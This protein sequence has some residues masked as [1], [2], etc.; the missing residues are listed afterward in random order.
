MEVYERTRE[1]HSAVLLGTPQCVLAVSHRVTGRS[2]PDDQRMSYPRSGVGSPD[3]RGFERA[4]RLLSSGNDLDRIRLGVGA[5][6]LGPIFAIAALYIRY[7][8]R[9]R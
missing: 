8:A 1:S 9:R 5:A 2:E 3:P 4:G 6:L 7:F